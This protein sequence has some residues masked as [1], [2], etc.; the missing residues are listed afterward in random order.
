LEPSRPRGG[1]GILI[2]WRYTH[3]PTT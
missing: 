2:V 3:V 1:G